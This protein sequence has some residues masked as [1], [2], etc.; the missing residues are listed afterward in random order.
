MFA[1]LVRAS[2]SY[3]RFDS[4]HAIDEKTLRVLVNLVRFT[5]SAANRQPLKFFIS[6]SAETNEQIFPCLAWAGYMKDWEGPA[7]EERP[8]AYI[9]VLADERIS[10]DVHCDH[11]IA[12]QTIMLGAAEQGLGGCIIASIKRA[13]LMQ[14]LKL[15]DYFRLLLVLALGKPAEQVVIEALD[16]DGS[17]QYWRDETGVHHVPK[18]TLNELIVS[19]GTRNLAAG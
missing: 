9:L 16:P 8:T 1:D 13:R 15:P 4:A 3:R 11:G 10:H 7:L 6:N 5:P 18:R 2:R 12:A 17:I 19:H 14:A